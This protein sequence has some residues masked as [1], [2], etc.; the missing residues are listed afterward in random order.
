MTTTTPDQLAYVVTGLAGSGT[1]WASAV[2]TAA[3][4]S[5]GHEA[6]FTGHPWDT[7]GGRWTTRHRL[8]VGPGLDGDSSWKAAPYVA[9][10][11]VPVV[12]LVRDPLAVVRSLSGLRLFLSDRCMASG[13]DLA[14]NCALRH[15]P[16]IADAGDRLGRI[17]R[18][19]AGWDLPVTGP[20]VE[21][22]HIDRPPVDRFRLADLA[23][24]LTGRTVHRRDA[25]RALDRIGRRHNSHGGHRSTITWQAVLEHPD[26]A[27][28]AE[29][30]CRYR[31][32]QETP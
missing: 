32:P 1:G 5:C 4:S 22:L 31:Y 12:H 3:G 17:L 16:A 28:V 23:A 30:A 7:A 26:G 19:V 29:R 21:V 15:L 9:E 18:Y 10:L 27:A 8:P 6:V 2:L 25:G 20:H 11:D 24:R 13:D 14:T